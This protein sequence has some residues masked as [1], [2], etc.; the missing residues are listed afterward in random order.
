M[1][2]NR[3]V[4]SPGLQLSSAVME[5]LAQCPGHA[6][7]FQPQQLTPAAVELYLAHLEQEG[8]GLPHRARVKSTI[9]KFA[10]K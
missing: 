10:Q 2:V 8:F 6:G 7:Q 5:W 3:E 1:K 9:S 4:K